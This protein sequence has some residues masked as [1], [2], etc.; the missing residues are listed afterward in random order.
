MQPDPLAPGT[1]LRERYRIQRSISVGG[2]GEVYRGVDVKSGETV[3]V[4]RC[5]KN[6]PGTT[7]DAEASYVARRV[8]EEMEMLR[9]LSFPGIPRFIDFF[10][11][12]QSES[13][14]EMDCL[15][16]EFIEGNDLNQQ[17]RDSVKLAGQLP[18]PAVSL[19]Y[20]VQICRILEHLHS[21]NPPV[22]HRDVKPSNM[23]L[24]HADSRV[25]LV[26]FGFARP[27][28]I[29]AGTKSMVGTLG[30]AP[31]EQ[32]Q[33]Q[34]TTRS[35][36]YGVG[37]TLFFLLTG[38]QPTPFA[39]EPIGKVRD[40]L[41]KRLERCVTKATNQNQEGR[42]RTITEMRK[43]LEAILADLRLEKSTAPR[44]GPHAVDDSVLTD[45][46]LVHPL[47][48]DERLAS[49]WKPG[50]PAAKKTS[51][52]DD[53]SDL[54]DLRTERNWLQEIFPSL[55][56]SGRVASRVWA[57]TFLGLCIV[58]G[59]FFLSFFPMSAGLGN[60]HLGGM[61]VQESFEAYSERR[62][63]RGEKL[64]CL[65]STQGLTT[66]AP[67]VVSF[68]A[69]E[70]P[71][72]APYGILLEGDWPQGSVLQILHKGGETVLH[73]RLKGKDLEKSYKV[74]L[75]KNNIPGRPP[76]D[77]AD[78]WSTKWLSEPM[79]NFKIPTLDSAELKEH[80]GGSLQWT[81]LF[82][83]VHSP[84]KTQLNLVVESAST[85]FTLGFQF[86]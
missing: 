56:V 44:R 69:V 9:R 12:P 54:G 84:G 48:S 50:S 11:I 60:L 14:I 59:A 86:K 13:N 19:E 47:K 30:Y 74:A 71:A 39:I 67:G 31:L 53:G 4:K 33:G 42:Y 68:P 45:K 21:L 34:P 38:Q 10:Q 17:I 85:P 80:H 18:D 79:E 82:L 20:A 73:L 40:D 3:A 52:A 58:F 22:V 1:V 55:D 76:Q 46:T 62:A 35:D 51:Q 15:V 7:A 83:E 57:L 72:N 26:D 41:P 65:A 81:S 27:I 63:S 28:G 29:T 8:L 37:A 75:T 24:R 5:L 70:P 78:I 32:C 36:Q 61:S 43:E 25:Y 77:T 23:I 49:P 64:V 6:E 2:W 16:M 66:A